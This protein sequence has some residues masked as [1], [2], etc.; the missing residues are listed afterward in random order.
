MTENESSYNFRCPVDDCSWSFKNLTGLTQHTQA[1]HP[2]KDVD[3]DMSASPSIA[4]TQLTTS[5]LTKPQFFPD[6]A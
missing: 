1:K 2:N 3:M 6:T 4:A 5:W